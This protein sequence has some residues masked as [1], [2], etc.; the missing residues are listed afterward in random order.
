MEL[1][2]VIVDDCAKE[3]DQ[4]KTTF[5]LMETEP[6]FTKVKFKYTVFNNPVDALGFE[7][8]IHIAL[9]DIEMPKINGFELAELVQKEH[10]RCKIIFVTSH[11]KYS[12]EGYKLR[13]FGFLIKPVAYEKMLYYISKAVRDFKSFGVIKV[14]IDGIERF[15]ELGDILAFEADGKASVVY[16]VDGKKGWCKHSLAKLESMLPKWVF[17][18]ASK[19]GLINFEH[20]SGRCSKTNEIIMKF[21]DV[22]KRFKIT[23]EKYLELFEKYHVYIIK[24]GER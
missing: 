18:R 22:E 21:K 23:S 3:S 4:V 11:I 8:D 9:I 20:Y 24:R 15:L 12:L 10:P 13:P 17:F 2:V 16:T 6:E 5:G 19:K 1:N 14:L 7:K